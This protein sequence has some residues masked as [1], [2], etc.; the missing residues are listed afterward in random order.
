[1]KM[2]SPKLYLLATTYTLMTLDE[3][4]Q[5]GVFE[6]VAA[7]TAS[8]GYAGFDI[9]LQHILLIGKDR[10]ASVMKE[11]NLKCIVKV[12]SSGGVGNLPSCNELARKECE[13]EHPEQGRTVEHHI[14][15]W[16]AQVREACTARI[17]P[18]VLGIG[19]HSGRDYFS[20]DEADTFFRAAIAVSDELGVPCFH[21]THR[22]KILFNPWLA[23][24]LV[25]RH[26]KL[27]LLGDLSHY[28][29]VCEAPPGDAELEGAIAKLLPRCGHLHARVGFEEG[30]QI[31]DPREPRWSKYVD[32]HL[33]WW[34]AAFR[35][36]A[37]RGAAHVTV[38]PEFLPPPY[39]WS[40]QSS[41]SYPGQPAVDVNAINHFMADLV[42]KAIKEEFPESC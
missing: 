38:T 37:A 35:S 25:E 10:F 40:L 33:A 34:K 18:F 29:C 9:A 26:S 21:E 13:L 19:S 2:S 3:C 12:Y 11:H 24:R 20:E 36:A 32:G 30:P 16:S 27:Q 6:R 42:R 28:C 22:H 5:S 8:R 31:L 15:V 7:D 39:C 14:A 1:M 4:S 23:V 41:D 17:R